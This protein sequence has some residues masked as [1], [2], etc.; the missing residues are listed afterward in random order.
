[1]AEVEKDDVGARRT[2][3]GLARAYDEASGDGAL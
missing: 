2:D 3:D 1:M